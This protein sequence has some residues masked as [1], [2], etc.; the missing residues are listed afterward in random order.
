MKQLDQSFGDQPLI[1]AT[2][3]NAIGE[4]YN[5]LGLHREALPV[6]EQALRL[7]RE[8]LGEDDPATLD[9]MNNLA[10]AYHDAGRFDLAIPLLRATLE[11]RRI[12]L[13]SDQPDDDRNNE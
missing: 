6:F 10:M 8:Q 3:L 7:R 12:V 2:L 1:K 4:T 5:G 11:K 13:G 9:S